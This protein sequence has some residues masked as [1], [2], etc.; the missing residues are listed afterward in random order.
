MRRFLSSFQGV[1]RAFHS[2]TLSKHSGIHNNVCETIGSTPIIKLNSV[3]PKGI[4]MYVKCEFFNPLGSVKDRL[5]IGII[6]HGERTGNL[7]PGQTVCEATS[8]NT[9]IGLAMVCAAKGYPLVITM[10]DSFSIER[11]KIMR[12]LGAKVVLT[13]AALKGTGMVEKARELAE[14]HSWFQTRQFENEA[15]P[16]YHAQTTGPEILSA[17]AGKRLDFW[18][19]GYGTGGTMSGAGKV[20]K[21]ARP[22]VKIILCE[23]SS[24]PLVSNG[25]KQE[26][27]ADGSPSSSHP[28]FTPH[29][30]QGWT[31]DFIPDITERGLHIADDL[32]LVEPQDAI[33]MALRLGSQE[34]LFTGI[35]GGA[36]VQAAVQLAENVPAGSSILAMLPDTAE[37]Y[38]STPMFASIESDMNA[39]ETE[40]SNS[41]PY[42]QFD[43]SA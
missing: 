3:A 43:D 28:S 16:A 7:K 37:R 31:P 35:S 40:L 33:D 15:N 12:S 29:P 14:K 23:P 1:C 20:I 18:V 25:I 21:Q 38:M 19:T 9:G 4:N 6:E 42:A 10:A 27:R 34:G 24:A 11:R 39:E 26:R 5:A 22:D 41:T 2:S 17:F 8:G 30:I 32:I 13:P 36:T